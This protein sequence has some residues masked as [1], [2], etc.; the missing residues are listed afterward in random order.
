MKILKLRIQGLRSLYDVTWT[1]GDL[2]VVIGPNG[3][4]KSNLLKAL[5]MLAA[6]AQGRLSEY[7][8]REGGMLPLLYDGVAPDA[9]FEL[10]ASQRGQSAGAGL[11]YELKVAR[12]PATSAPGVTHELVADSN[13]LRL[14][15]R[16]SQRAV[17]RV[18]DGPE[19]IL[20]AESFRSEETFLSLATGP[21][22]LNWPISGFRNWLS[23]WGIYQDFVT[24]RLSPARQVALVRYDTSI[25]PDGSN[26]ITALH[27]LY[28]GNRDFERDVDTGMTAAFGEDFEKL[29]FP[30]AADERVQLR[31]RW[32]S[33]QREQSAAD[34]S[35]GTLRFLFLITVLANPKPPPLIAIDE[36]ETGLHPSM[37][38]IVA[39][40]A[41]E[42]ASRT[43]VVLTTH[44]AEFLDAFGETRPPRPWP[45][46]R[47]VERSCK[48]CLTKHSATG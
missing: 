22:G 40:Y 11:T 13:D 28:T 34:L 21:L 48:C 9:S 12:V 3:S 19:T 42:A 43:Q 17:V 15:E 16:S 37:L 36:P 24:A 26:L 23:E 32:K 7:V 25:A 1:P 44:S 39:E 29:T 6:S 35:D 41:V 14:M 10:E 47:M 33:L 8:Q 27:T 20:P 30:P 31:I 46:G 4:G 45:N 5:E 2:N 18:A 38:P